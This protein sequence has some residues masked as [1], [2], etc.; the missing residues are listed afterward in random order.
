MAYLFLDPAPC[1]LSMSSTFPFPAQPYPTLL[2]SLLASI[3]PFVSLSLMLFS[4][5]LSSHVGSHCSSHFPDCASAWFSIL[6]T[7]F[8][9]IQHCHRR[10]CNRFRFSVCMLDELEH[11]RDDYRL[12]L[13]S[14]PV[15]LCYGKMHLP[16]AQT[17]VVSRGLVEAFGCFLALF[18]IDGCCAR[19]GYGP[20]VF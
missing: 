7:P 18:F 19:S 15:N 17:V 8:L 6:L 5:C 10:I 12:M 3:L 13:G 1:Q 16:L 14:Q 9:N 4:F 2:R 20:Q 11:C